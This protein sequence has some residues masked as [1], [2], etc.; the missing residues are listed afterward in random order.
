MVLAIDVGATKTAWALSE[1]EGA[2]GP[3]ERR[4]TKDVPSLL[5]EIVSAHAKRVDAIGIALVGHVDPAALRWNEALTIAGSYPQDLRALTSLPLCIDNDLKAATLAEQTHGW[6]RTYS[7]VLC[8]NLGSGVSLGIIS[9]GKLQRGASNYSGEVGHM[10]VW[11]GK[12]YQ[13]LEQLLGGLGIQSY[14][15]GQGILG[16]AEELFRRFRMGEQKAGERV[17]FLREVLVNLLVALI[18]LYNPQ[19]VA[20]SGSLALQKPLTDSLETEVRSRLLRVS[21]ESLKVIA[22]SL[23]G[24]REISLLGASQLAW[25]ELQ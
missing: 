15:A 10:P 14:L 12:K 21:E 8:L 2:L 16:G 18:H 6:G 5:Q 13:P 7:E 24:A 9:G 22:P 23:L 4:P 19:C 20:L 11:D 3:I 25:E 17:A 1:A